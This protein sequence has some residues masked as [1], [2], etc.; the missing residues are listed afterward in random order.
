MLLAGLKVQFFNQ[1]RLSLCFV[2]FYSWKK[3]CSLVK[4]SSKRLSKEPIKNQLK[5]LFVYNES[6]DKENLN[7]RGNT[8]EEYQEAI[9]I[10]EK[11]ENITKTNKRNIIRFASQQGKLLKKFTEN[12][13]F[14]NLVEQFRINKSTMII[15]KILLN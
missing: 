11:Y 12:R 14:K 1:K 6:I 9:N 5:A 4:R 7:A 15:K 13:K 2:F 10:I 3:H 8:A